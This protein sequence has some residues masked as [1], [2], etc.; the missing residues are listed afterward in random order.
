LP[1]PFAIEGGDASG[2]PKAKMLVPAATAKNCW[3][4][5]A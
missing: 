5:T 1:P 4:S 2:K 3:P